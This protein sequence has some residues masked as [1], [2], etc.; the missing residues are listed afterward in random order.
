MSTSFPSAWYPEQ[1]IRRTGLYQCLGESPTGDMC[2][3]R[4][5]FTRAKGNKFPR[6]SEPHGA[7]SPRWEGP[8]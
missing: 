4:F 2:P 8:L 1:A 6:C 7:A 3:A 5:T